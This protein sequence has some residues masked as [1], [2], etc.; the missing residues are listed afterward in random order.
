VYINSYYVPDRSFVHVT[1]CCRFLISFVFLTINIPV[2]Y[3][4]QDVLILMGENP[5]RGP[6]E[7]VGPENRNFLGP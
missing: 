3:T 2:V 6:L 4:A 1:V 5:F 7:G